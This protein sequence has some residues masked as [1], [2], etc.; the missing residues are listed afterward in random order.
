[1][2]DTRDKSDRGDEGMRV[3]PTDADRGDARKTAPSP[4]SGS[5]VETGDFE[6][7]PPTERDTSHGIETPGAS[8]SDGDTQSLAGSHGTI[9]T[10]SIE[11]DGS[12]DDVTA[13]YHDEGATLSFKLDSRFEDP[14]RTLP[15][16]PEEG[17]E[18]TPRVAGHVILG[19]LGEGGMGIV[20]KARHLRLDRLVALKMI[21]AGAGTRSQIV[22]R[23]EAE[24]RAVAGIK[25][26]NI[27]QIF[28]IG[29]HEGQPYFSLE[30]L[31]GGN[32]AKKIGGKPQPVAEAARIVEVLARAIQVAH[33]HEKKII[34]RD[35]KPANVLL[36]VD[37]TLKIA[38]FGL[39]KELEGE[40]GRTNTGSILGTPSYMAPEQARGES[41]AVGPAADQYA[42]GAI[43]YEL[44][45]GRPPFHGPSAFDTLE[46]VRNKEPVPP[47]RL[48]PKMHRDI[49]TICLKCLEKDPARRYPDVGALAEDLRRFQTGEPIVARPVSNPERL[50]RWCLRNKRVAALAATVALLLILVVAGSVGAAYTINLKNQALN[51]ANS[52]AEERRIEAESKQK[53]AETAQR[54]AQTAARA[55]IDQNRSV[56]DA[57]TNLTGLLL[58]KLRYVPAIQDVRGQLLDEAIKSLTAAAEGMT[59]LPRRRLGPQGR[60][61]QLEVGGQG[62][63][64]DR[65]P[66]P[67]A[68]TDRGC[69]GAI[70]AHEFHYRGTDCDRPT[71]RPL[72]TDSAGPE[73][74]TTRVR[75]ISIPGRYGCGP[76]VFPQ[77]AG[78]QSGMSGAQKR[79]RPK[80]RSRQHARS[81]RRGRTVARTS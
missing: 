27:V 15:P 36:D 43:L 50:W 60:G 63:S 55:A 29:E 4:A 35:L 67:H 51:V 37:G 28:E 68:T 12:T 24:A 52:K 71:G 69:N 10:A 75:R 21:R 30:F 23:F 78:D 65:R 61:A 38:D 62:T 3:R 76:A 45:T 19:I 20:F 57:D 1:M 31:G 47:S 13:S 25:H 16:S 40:S 58:E 56:V 42:L 44:L 22:E 7:V 72:G 64:A 18:G 49:E 41:K 59:N 73:P 17:T 32:L 66:L 8:A 14:E 48:Q 80:V 81:N 9:D 34:H 74:A 70:S 11:P 53:I 77:S 26:P 79:R 54:L 5:D 46:M 2:N 39:V 6:P 33:Q